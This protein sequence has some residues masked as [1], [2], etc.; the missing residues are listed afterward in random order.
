MAEPQPQSDFLRN[1]VI[2]LA[3]FAAALL[4][5]PRLLPTPTHTP[6]QQPVAQP[7]AD[8]VVGPDAAP[9]QPA[10][11]AAAAGAFQ[12]QEAA[13]SQTAT[14]GAELP[15][16]DLPARQRRKRDID[17]RMRLTLSNVG[18]SVVSAVMTDYDESVESPEPYRVLAPLPRADAEYRSF[19][20]EKINLDSVDI[21]LADRRWNMGAAESFEREG[22]SGQQVPFWIDV[23]RDGQP[24][25]RLT[26]TYVL[27]K[28]P[29]DQ[30]RCD[31][32]ADLVVE[33]LSG[34]P[35]QVVVTYRGG[36][37]VRPVSPRMDDRFVITG[38]RRAGAVSGMRKVRTDVVHNGS[39]SLNLY[40][41][42]GAPDQRLSWVSVGNTYFTCVVAPLNPDAKS[43]AE[44]I[45]DVS[46]VDLDGLATTDD[47]LTT[48]VVTTAGTL[49]AGGNLR[50]P[51]EMY[52]GPMSVDAF[53]DVP[54]Y[55]DRNY[56]FQISQ[57]YGWC[58][59]AALVELMIWLLNG[60]HVV[61]PN[62]GLAIIVLVLVVRA[63]LHP[64]TKMGQVNMARMQHRMQSLAPKLEELKK[65][66][67]KDKTRLNQEV[68]ALYQQEGMNPAG[69]F[70]TCLPMALQMPIWVALYISL[71]HNIAM[72][73]EPFVLWIDDLTT[74][75]LLWAFSSP[76]VVPLVGWHIYGLN[77]LPIILAVAMYIQQKL[78]PKPAPNPNMSEQQKQQ[79]EMMQKMM[80]M[81]TIMMLLIFYNMPSGL[82]L[83]VMSST[84]FGTIEQVVIRR[85]IKKHEAAGTLH[86]RPRPS[87]G[88]AKKKR[89]EEMS[90]FEKLQRMAEEAQK[91][92]KARER[93]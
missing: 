35:H 5:L 74:P 30:Q 50:F 68:M 17:Y 56:Y 9:A 78:Q 93:R 19:A 8:V 18:A 90:F 85:H 88:A 86:K 43:E 66:Y 83:Y 1:L 84:I 59:F 73:H 46:A 76:F 10:P 21:P 67:A 23:H 7:G 52:V 55:L 3:I 15:V 57:S 29:R 65:K 89:P 20:I 32:L 42:A 51:A 45:A 26:R 28:Q 70:L 37:G 49:P 12:V 69:Q 54:A 25:V 40:S 36:C 61:L 24:V 81:M 63:L 11:G 80:P 6:T 91:S 41:R 22:Q 39:V 31:L 77:L 38:V 33:N 44:N 60:I 92:Q 16:D 58:T 4:I 87:E 71:S 27:P 75:D 47:D 14:I 64:I 2:S 82:T 72:R 34:E 48:R 62:Y 53:K 79:Q 13:E